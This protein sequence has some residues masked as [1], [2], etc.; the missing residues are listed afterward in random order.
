MDPDSARAVASVTTPSRPAR[1]QQKRGYRGWIVLAICVLQSGCS[2]DEVA[3]PGIDYVALSGTVSDGEGPLSGFQF[4]LRGGETS[5]PIA[6]ATSGTFRVEIPL[7][8]YDVR[9]APA[10][11]S[12][13]AV[14]QLRRVV[15][16]QPGEQSLH[17][18]LASIHLNVATPGAQESDSVQ[19]AVYWNTNLVAAQQ[20]TVREHQA[21]LWFRGLIPAFTPALVGV[22]LEGAPELY[23]APGVTEPEP[24][25]YVPLGPDSTST[26]SFAV[27]APGFAVQPF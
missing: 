2:D 18:A 13:G 6:T 15:F 4:T 17:I 9:L 5:Y 8:G 20:T 11:P 12:T 25:S 27:P 22:A 14:Q 7:G 10:P 16:D 21:D 23:F 26:T 1:P 19:A 24:A 3:D